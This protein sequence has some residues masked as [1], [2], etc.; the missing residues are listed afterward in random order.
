VVGGGGGVEEA[1]A[2]AEAEAEGAVS[3]RS[4]KHNEH[5]AY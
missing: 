1:E 3:H 5:I 2:E 4:W